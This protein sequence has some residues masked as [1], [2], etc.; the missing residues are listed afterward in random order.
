MNAPVF[1]DR[2]DIVHQAVCEVLCA[3]F[4]TIRPE[5]LLCSARITA[6]TAWVRQA[7][8]Y[9]MAGRLGCSHRV[10]AKHF[11]RDRT[12]VLHAVQLAEEEIGER[13]D[14]AAFIDFLEARVRIRLGEYAV[15]E[16]TWG[17]V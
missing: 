17:G 10:T 9:L 3:V 14:T 12:T 1:L 5:A 13:P 4:P 2:P 15:A 8:M 7:G 16:D 11:G 6:T